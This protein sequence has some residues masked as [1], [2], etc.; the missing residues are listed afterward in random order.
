M[1]ADHLVVEKAEFG[2]I[3]GWQQ[4][5]VRLDRRDLAPDLV[6]MDGSPGAELLLQ[7]AEV[8]QQFRRAHVRRPGRD[9]DAHSTVRLAVPFAMKL[10][11]VDHVAFAELSVELEGRRIADLRADP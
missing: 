2:E 6:E 11:D 4:V 1:R 10:L 3:L 7:G 8:T 9:C 5:A